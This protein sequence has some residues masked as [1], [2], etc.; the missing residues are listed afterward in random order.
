M[1]KWSKTYTPFDAFKQWNLSEISMPGFKE[2]SE[3]GDADVIENL[4]RAW[5]ALEKKLDGFPKFPMEITTPKLFNGIRLIES[6]RFLHELS[7]RASLYYTGGLNYST[8]M[9]CGREIGSMDNWDCPEC[10][11]NYS[12]VTKAKLPRGVVSSYYK[13]SYDWTLKPHNLNVDLDPHMSADF[14]V[15]LAQQGSD[16]TLDLLWEAWTEYVQDEKMQIT[17]EKFDELRV[18]LDPKDDGF[19]NTLV[20]SVMIKS[21]RKNTA[22]ATSTATATRNPHITTVS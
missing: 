9:C 11:T 1:A 2:L 5:S 3:H 20:S 6:S 12:G 14:I 21:A 16:K 7:T 4:W 13:K 8:I 22:T 19:F 10:R 18:S 15:T 17:R